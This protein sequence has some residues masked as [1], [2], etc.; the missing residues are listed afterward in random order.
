MKRS[1][2]SSYDEKAELIYGNLNYENVPVEHVD[3]ELLLVDRDTEVN[4]NED[5][6][7]TV[8]DVEATQFEARL[9]A[10]KINEW[11]GKKD[12]RPLQVLDKATNKLR[13]IQFRD[14]VI[15]LRSLTGVPTIVD[16]LKKQGIPVHAELRT[17]YFEAIE[18]KVM[19]NMLKIIDN[20]YQDIPLVSVLRS[21]IVGL[22][23]EQLAQ[24]RLRKNLNL[25][26]EALK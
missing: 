16:E 8:E 1:E 21:P 9:Y 3:T 17:G 18:I 25:S 14:I 4:S 23:E 24:I 11:I 7:E 10:E 19:I 6:D 15:L 2:K 20:P 13:D 5:G 12:K 22:N 26:T